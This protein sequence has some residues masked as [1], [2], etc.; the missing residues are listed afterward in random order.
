MVTEALHEKCSSELTGTAKKL[1]VIIVV[2]LKYCHCCC[3]RQIISFWSA[4]FCLTLATYSATRQTVAR[5]EVFRKFLHSLRLRQPIR[6]PIA[7]KITSVTDALHVPQT[8][9]TRWKIAQSP[10]RIYFGLYKRNTSVVEGNAC[11]HLLSTPLV[12]IW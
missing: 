2:I 12:K 8:D 6:S 10:R 5:F 1:S 11:V 7:N 9:C 4:V 3:C